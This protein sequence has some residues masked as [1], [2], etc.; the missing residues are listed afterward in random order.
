MTEFSFTLQHKENR[1]AALQS[2][3]PWKQGGCRG[4]QLLGTPARTWQTYWR[5]E[6]PTPRATPGSSDK[7]MQ[8]VRVGASTGPHLHALWAF[9]Q[10]DRNFL[11][12]PTMKQQEDFGAGSTGK[13]TKFPCQKWIYED[14][15][16]NETKVLRLKPMK[17]P[18]FGNG[19][20]MVRTERDGEER[21]MPRVGTLPQSGQGEQKQKTPPIQNLGIWN[22]ESIPSEGI[23]LCLYRVYIRA[24]YQVTVMY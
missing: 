3:C 22:T 14:S 18:A 16:W 13:I 19:T 8:C 6:S 4:H 15:L 24:G 20:L 17:M 7:P 2:S 21:T 10:R 5:R 11:S 12:C 1:F 9:Q 23:L